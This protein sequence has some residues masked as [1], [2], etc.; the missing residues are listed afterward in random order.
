MPSS[1]LGSLLLAL[2]GVLSDIDF[3][4]GESAIAFKLRI[5][6]RDFCRFQ[7]KN[8][9]ILVL[10]IVCIIVFGISQPLCVI[11]DL[12]FLK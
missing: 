1:K 5:H 12:Q 7:E 2:F 6:Y 4:D 9:S 8:D 11:N 10:Q 3:V